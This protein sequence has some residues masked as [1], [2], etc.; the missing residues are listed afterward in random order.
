VNDGSARF[1]A[2]LDKHDQ[3][4]KVPFCSGRKWLASGM[5]NAAGR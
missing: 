4:K 5:V 3:G 1:D 2:Q